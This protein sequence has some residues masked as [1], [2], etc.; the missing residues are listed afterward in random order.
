MFKI[1]LIVSVA[2]AAVS[3]QFFGGGESGGLGE[4]GGFG[5]FGGGGDGDEHKD[6][7]AY[8]KYKFEYGVKDH[9][10]G[11]HKNHWEIRDG[12]VVKG[13]YS[14]H[15]PDGTQRVV[16]YKSDKHTGFEA[17][18]KRIGHGGHPQLYGGHQEESIGGIGGI[19]G[20]Y[21]H[22]DAFSYS[23]VQHHHL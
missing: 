8:P 23:N 16:E 3:A 21:E 4:S 12:D 5:G 15:E 7:Y 9:K 14:L 10:T 22:G 11:D 2:L 19:E 20:G 1:F 18:V 13:E 6:Y 17:H